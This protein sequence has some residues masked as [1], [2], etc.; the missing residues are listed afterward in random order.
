M[1]RMGQSYGYM[2]YSAVLESSSELNSLKLFKAADRAIAF[3]DK[4]RAMTAYDRELEV[5][6][7]VGPFHGKN[8]HLD[9][10][11]ENMG[12][13]NYGPYLNWQRKGIDGCVMINDR[14]AQHNWKQYALPMTN[15]DQ[16]NF[17]AG[18]EE[19]LPA[20]YQVEFN[21]DE[22]ADTFLD[23]TGW[24][25]GFVVVNAFNLGRFWE[26]GPQRRLYLPGALLKPGKNELLIF[27]TEGKHKATVILCD[28]PDLGDE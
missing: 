15:L 24:G 13:V 5:R 9:I 17:E 8:M 21:V 20:F 22:P 19:G 23:M 4:Q 3:I 28:T 27:E 2:L 1:E 6:H 12:R 25:K 11:V 10:L 16:L 18:Y 26:E 7:E 14:F